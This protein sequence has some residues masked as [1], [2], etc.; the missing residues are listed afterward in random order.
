[1]DEFSKPGST[2][3]LPATRLCICQNSLMPGF[4]L[5]Q[6]NAGGGE[7]SGRARQ[8]GNVPSAQ[9]SSP[10]IPP[11]TRGCFHL[12]TELQQSTPSQTPVSPGLGLP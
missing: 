4:H 6:E 11:N 1:M 5:S 10:F 7:E 3:E 12:C 8:R 9:V 2:P